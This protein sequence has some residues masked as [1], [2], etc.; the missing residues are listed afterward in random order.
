MKET[1]TIHELIEKS[2]ESKL[3]TDGHDYI[4]EGR[5]YRALTEQDAMIEHECF[6]LYGENK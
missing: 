4:I 5:K 6:K 2:I 1:T 3:K